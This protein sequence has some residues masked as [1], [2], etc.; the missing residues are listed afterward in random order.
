MFSY[1]IVLLWSSESDVVF[2]CAWY[3]NNF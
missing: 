2:L 3:K 1:D